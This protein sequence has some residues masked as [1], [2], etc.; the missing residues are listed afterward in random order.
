MKHAHVLSQPKK[1]LIMEDEEDMRQLLVEEC[2]HAGFTVIEAKNGKEGLAA[3]KKEHPDIILLDIVMPEMDGM[4][5][6]SAIRKDTWGKTV[7][8]ILLTNLSI[9]EK[10]LGGILKGEPSYYLV[11]SDWKMS[12]IV[13]K[14]IERLSSQ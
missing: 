10:I 7:P 13:Q 6:L 4:D 14:I 3:A 1:I 8:I 12:E 9:N 5:V 2:T 11:K